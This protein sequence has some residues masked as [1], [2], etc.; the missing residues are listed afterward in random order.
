MRY[1][2]LGSIDTRYSVFNVQRDV[3]TLPKV[4]H[5]TTQNKEE[6]A[7]LSFLYSLRIYTRTWKN[8]KN[9]LIKVS[10]KRYWFTALWIEDRNL[11]CAWFFGAIMSYKKSR[12]AML[13]KL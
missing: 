9:D 10:Y 12:V 8:I 7:L 3:S 5:K 13:P 1:K 4:Q 6:E 2:S 11:R